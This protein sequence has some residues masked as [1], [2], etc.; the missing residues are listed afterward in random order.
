M[1][2]EWKCP[3][4]G[5]VSQWSHHDAAF[6][7][8]H[9]LKGERSVAMGLVLAFLL[10]G[11][12]LQMV[13]LLARRSTRYCKVK[14]RTHTEREWELRRRKKH[15][16]NKRNGRKR[17]A[18]KKHDWNWNVNGFARKLLNKMHKQPVLQEY[19]NVCERAFSEWKNSVPPKR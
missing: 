4:R 10:C 16:F 9:S 12:F 14:L 11:W 8:A 1:N 19:R 7:I 5:S 6:A 15:N 3:C 13:P 17:R 2:R 18:G